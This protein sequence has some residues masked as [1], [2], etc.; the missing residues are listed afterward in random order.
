[1]QFLASSTTAKQVDFNSASLKVRVASAAVNVLKTFAGERS[2][3][4]G[5]YRANRRIRDTPFRS[6]EF[7]G[8]YKAR[9]RGST[10]PTK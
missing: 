9:L 8:L 4:D 1:M 3:S 2:K 7:H 10:Y 6:T 5:G